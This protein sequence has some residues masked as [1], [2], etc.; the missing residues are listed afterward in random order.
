[1]RMGQYTDNVAKGNWLR[2]YS[3]VCVHI[4]EI[5]ALICL[6]AILRPWTSLVLAN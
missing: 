2:D 3:Q 5:D 4:S 6:F 1:M